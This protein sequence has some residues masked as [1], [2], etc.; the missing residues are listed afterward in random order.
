MVS[1]QNGAVKMGREKMEPWFG[2]GTKFRVDKIPPGDLGFCE[3]CTQ[4]KRQ[5]L[6]WKEVLL[7]PKFLCILH[8]SS[9]L[10]FQYPIYSKLCAIFFSKISIF[11]CLLLKFE[12]QLNCRCYQKFG[13]EIGSD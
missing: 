5:P 2:G 11:A 8:Y 3:F 13:I 12:H 4:D 1:R 6:L 10:Q 7:Y 9:S